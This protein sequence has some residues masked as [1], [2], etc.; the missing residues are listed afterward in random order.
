V[1]ATWTDNDGQSVSR[2]REVYVQAN[3]QAVANFMQNQNQDRNPTQNQN[4][5]KNQI[6]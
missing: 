4:Q 6:R 1:Q 5:D 2:T 3:Q